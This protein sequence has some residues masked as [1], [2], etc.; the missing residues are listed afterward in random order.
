MFT[1]LV[2]PVGARARSG[3][4]VP[5]VLCAAVA[6]FVSGCGGSGTPEETETPAATTTATDASHENHTT[7]RVSFVEPKDGATLSSKSLTKFVFATD[8]YQI[9]AVP[10]GEVKEARPEIGHFH[11]GVDSD[12][13][14]AGTVIPKAEAGARP[15]PF[16]R[17]GDPE[18]AREHRVGRQD[19][20]DGAIALERQKE[21]LAA[22][23]GRADTSLN[24]LCQLLGGR[25]YQ[26]RGRRRGLEHGAAGDSPLELLGHDGEVGQLRHEVGSAL[27]VWYAT[28]AVWQTIP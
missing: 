22:P 14:P 13:L 26:N 19:P 11:L 8:A 23:C 18:P 10:A 16:A 28:R 20:S 7:A 12:C 3:V 25:P 4:F 24:E 9:G 6:L 2:L 21:E 1:R 27:T 5:T 15:N 17:R